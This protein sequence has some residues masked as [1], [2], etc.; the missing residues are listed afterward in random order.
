V[1]K[2]PCCIQHSVADAADAGG[3][4]DGYAELA[5]VRRAVRVRGPTQAQRQDDEPAAEYAQI[6]HTLHA[7]LNER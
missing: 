4:G 6:D 3:D 2:W 5:V 1:V 7:K